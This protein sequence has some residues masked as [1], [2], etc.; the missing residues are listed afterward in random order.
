MTAKQ[1][2]AEL[3][4]LNP[5]VDVV[6]YCEDRELLRNDSRFR[7]LE[8]EGVDS[9]VGEKV[10]V[11]GVP[12]IKMGEPPSATMVGRLHVTLDFAVQSTAEQTAAI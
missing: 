8:I 10:N 12:T 7:L 11:D 2:I 9:T 1:L 3:S 6:C 4:K 5:D